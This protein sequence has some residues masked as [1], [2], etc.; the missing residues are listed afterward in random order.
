MSLRSGT[1]W[2]MHGSRVSSAAARTGSAEFSRALVTERGH[3]GLM[4]PGFACEGGRLWRRSA[5]PHGGHVDV[6]HPC[7]DE[8]TYFSALGLPW[9]PPPER[10][11]EAARALAKV[12][13]GPV[14]CDPCARDIQ[15]RGTIGTKRRPG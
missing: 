4:P 11:G 8:D 2:M 12:E 1:W 7:S 5:L 9:L 13:D 3:G 6:F 10:T 15:A 14:Y